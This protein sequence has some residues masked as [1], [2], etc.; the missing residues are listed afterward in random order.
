VSGVNYFFRYAG[1][2]AAL[3]PDDLSTGQRIDPAQTG[4]IRQVAVN[5]PDGTQAYDCVGL[6]SSQ[7]RWHSANFE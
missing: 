7:E 6:T 5:P 1:I 3:A 2:V 4:A